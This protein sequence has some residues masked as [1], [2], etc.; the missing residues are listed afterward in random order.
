[1]KM[2][3][4]R[5]KKLE[6]LDKVFSSFNNNKK[7]ENRCTMTTEQRME[8]KL[9]NNQINSQIMNCKKT[10]KDVLSMIKTYKGDDL[11]TVEAVSQVIIQVIQQRINELNKLKQQINQINLKKNIQK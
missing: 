3:N 6:E 10:L 4:E 2:D 7:Q 8:L 1:M 11:N 9:M 5:L